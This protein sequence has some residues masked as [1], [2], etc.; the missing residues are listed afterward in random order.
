MIKMEKKTNRCCNLTNL[1]L[2]KITFK[3]ILKIKEQVRLIHIPHFWKILNALRPQPSLFI[4]KL[5]IISHLQHSKRFKKSFLV[6]A[7]S[8][9][10]NNQFT[11][12][13]NK[14]FP[15][16]KNLQNTIFLM[17]VSNSLLKKKVLICITVKLISPWN[18]PLKKATNFRES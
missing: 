6:K 1:P 4:Q 13:M 17:K 10:R 11:K 9:K 7:R 5:K 15:E 18:K 3:I 8:L 16:M 2:D 14:F 12:L